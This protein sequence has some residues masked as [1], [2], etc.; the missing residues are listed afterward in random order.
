MGTTAT[1][2]TA[3]KLI[4]ENYTIHIRNFNC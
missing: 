3:S 4:T 2:S 1:V